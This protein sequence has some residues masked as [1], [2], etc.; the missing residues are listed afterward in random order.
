MN[1]ISSDLDESMQEP[2]GQVFQLLELLRTPQMLQDGSPPLHDAD[3]VALRCL[4][5]GSASFSD[6]ESIVSK[7]SHSGLSGRSTLNADGCVARLCG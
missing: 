5:Q 6:F 2:T 7:L 4:R 3:S 1:N